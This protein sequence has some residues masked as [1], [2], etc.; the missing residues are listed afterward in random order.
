MLDKTKLFRLVREALKEIKARQNKREAKESLV[1][2]I[3]NLSSVPDQVQNV[4]IACD[5]L[6]VNISIARACQ[7]WCLGPVHMSPVWWEAH[8]SAM[9]YFC[10]HLTVFRRP[11]KLKVLL[12]RIFRPRFFLLK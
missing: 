12:Q 1:K 7:I 11:A 4:H 5:L 3:A 10:V 2:S 8:L 6:F 9:N